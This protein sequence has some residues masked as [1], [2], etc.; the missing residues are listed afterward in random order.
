MSRTNFAA[1]VRQDHNGFFDAG[2]GHAKYERFAST[3]P[4]RSAEAQ[5]AFE[6]RKGKRNKPV[7]EGRVSWE[8]SETIQGRPN[9]TRGVAA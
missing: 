5:E 4:R 2:N 1:N 6:A 3:K 9:G 8:D 7:R